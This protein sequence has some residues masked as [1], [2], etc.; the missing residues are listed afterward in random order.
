MIYSAPSSVLGYAFGRQNTPWIGHLSDI[1]VRELKDGQSSDGSPTTTRWSPLPSPDGAPPPPVAV[2][3]HHP[4]G[5][6]PPPCGPP[7]SLDGP[8]ASTSSRTPGPV[9]Q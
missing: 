9:L 6:P 8:A 3:R 5:P 1:P 2:L 4:M 7:P